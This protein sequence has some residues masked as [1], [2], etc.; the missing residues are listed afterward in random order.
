MKKDVRRSGAQINY[1]QRN[2]MQGSYH[3]STYN[4]NRKQY[5]TMASGYYMH[6][7]NA[8]AH[9]YQYEEEQ[10]P[11]LQ[12]ERKPKVKSRPVLAQH[13]STLL[14]VF[15]LGL[16][17]VVQ[18]AYIQNLGYQVGQTKT[19]LKT[20]RDENEK[21][22]KQIA[23]KGEL[24]TVESIAVNNMGMRKPESSEII[25]LQKNPSA[26]QQ[27]TAET[28]NDAASVTASVSETVAN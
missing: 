20:V 13:I 1:T 7:A 27:I 22:K 3:K 4:N 23:T 14:V 10:Q 25:Y 9:D 16:V 8:V 12:K 19:E 18:Y 26:Q 5:Q 6:T 15:L 21:I 24:Q 11:V 2:S 17:L 28:A